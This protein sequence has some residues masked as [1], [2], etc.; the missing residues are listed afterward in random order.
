M[1]KVR[2]NMASQG[3]CLAELYYLPSRSY[4]I[5][6]ELQ[7]QSWDHNPHCSL[8][9]QRGLL[10]NHCHFEQACQHNASLQLVDSAVALG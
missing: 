3:L 7:E 1:Q 9:I 6:G 4:K 8:H 10:L 5:H 2:S